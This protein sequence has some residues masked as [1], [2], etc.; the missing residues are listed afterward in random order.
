VEQVMTM[1]VHEAFEDRF[2][3]T[4]TL[5]PILGTVLGQVATRRIFLSKP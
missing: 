4:T 1:Q 5:D 2:E 3:R